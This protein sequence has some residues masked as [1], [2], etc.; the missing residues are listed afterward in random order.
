[1]EVTNTQIS[2]TIRRPSHRDQRAVHV[3]PAFVADL[4]EDAAMS[5]TIRNP[6]P[7]RAYLG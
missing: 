5:A 2:A 1:L 3:V 4:G 7:R 6:N